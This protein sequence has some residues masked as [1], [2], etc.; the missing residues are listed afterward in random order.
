MPKAE[1]FGMLR[2]KLLAEIFGRN[3][4]ENIRKMFKAFAS[5]QLIANADIT[6]LAAVIGKE[7]AEKL[8]AIL[9]LS[10]GVLKKDYPHS[11]FSRWG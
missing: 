3:G 1:I 11:A 8:T 2:S 10:Q 7:A 4:T 5:I 9:V 6:E